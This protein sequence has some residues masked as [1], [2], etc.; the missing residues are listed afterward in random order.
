MTDALDLATL[1][2]HA[3]APSTLFPMF[4]LAYKGA[5]SRTAMPEVQ[6]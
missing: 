3:A 1:A 4:D 2:L 6:S 5:L